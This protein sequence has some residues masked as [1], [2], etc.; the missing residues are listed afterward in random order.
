MI[1]IFY[2]ILAFAS[3]GFYVHPACFENPA[4]PRDLQ[5]I[6]D[7]DEYNNPVNEHQRRILDELY[8]ERAPHS[9]EDR[10]NFVN[11]NSS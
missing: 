3:M 8:P 1:R 5:D 11:Y 7:E 10:K 2:I 4:H 9:E 6:K